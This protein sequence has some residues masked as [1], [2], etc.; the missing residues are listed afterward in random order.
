MERDI[1]RIASKGFSSI[2]L[3]SPDCSVLYFIGPIAKKYG[4]SLILGIYVSAPPEASLE[5]GSAHPSEQAGN[6][7]Q[8]QVKDI[9]TWAQGDYSQVEM[10]VVGDEAIFNDFITGERLA[11]I[12]SST[13][14]QLRDAGFQGPVTTTEP[15]MKL[16]ENALE[17][18]PVLDV[19]AANIQPYFSDH[20]SPE[21]AGRFLQD[22]LVVLSYVCGASQGPLPTYSMETGWPKEGVR[23]GEA[24]AG[25]D[26]QWIAMQS[27]LEQ[28]AEVVRKTVLG[29]WEDE[30]W[31]EEGEWGVE[32]SW[33][34]EGAFGS[35]L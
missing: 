3:H 6:E 25:V 8:A 10:V 19:V 27:I 5:N 22:E 24:I 1:K 4:I 32:R 23:N 20:V 9:I 11:A 33:G 28:G 29:S 35:V 7:V 14:H 12:I 34:I 26:E 2:R 16:A 13:R 15:I 30:A 21:N 18:C 31:R 17:L